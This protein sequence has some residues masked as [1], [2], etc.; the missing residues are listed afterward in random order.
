MTKEWVEEKTR[1]NCLKVEKEFLEI[2]NRVLNAPKITGKFSTQFMENFK[3]LL[4]ITQQRDGPGDKEI[5]QL[6]LKCGRLYG[7]TF[8]NHN[9]LKSTEDSDEVI[10]YLKTIDV[11]IVEEYLRRKIPF[12]YL[13]DSDHVSFTGDIIITD[14]CYIV[15][16]SD[17]DY[18]EMKEFFKDLPCMERDTIYGD[19]GC[20]TYLGIKDDKECQ[21]K[22]A[23]GEFYAASGIVCVARLSDVLAYNK[24]FDYHTTRPLTATVIKN[25]DGEIHFAVDRQEYADN[26][27]NIRESFDVSLVGSGVDSETG[28]PINFFTSQ[29][30]L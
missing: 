10:E 2:Y 16:K 22:H 29:T 27:G 4:E 24:D 19:W 18:E 15:K 8:Y 17:D 12:N 1:I 21:T 23:I 9:W 25:F 30:S 7:Q 26:D 13:L 6:I 14:P 5:F 11:D 28:S 20:T 3:R